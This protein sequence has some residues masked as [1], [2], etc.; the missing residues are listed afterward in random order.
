VNL[1]AHKGEVG[2]FFAFHTIKQIFLLTRF[3]HPHMGV[4]E[5]GTAVGGDWGIVGKCV[6]ATAIRVGTVGPD[7]FGDYH[8]WTHGRGQFGM[9]GDGPTFVDEANKIT[10]GNSC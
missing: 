1:V 5:C 2:A 6:D 9:K 8:A 10:V 7:T 4:V 3:F